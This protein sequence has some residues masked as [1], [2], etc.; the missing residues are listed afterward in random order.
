M[1]LLQP[2]E[3]GFQRSDRPVHGDEQELP[4]FDLNEI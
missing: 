1:R 4:A 2:A 3:H